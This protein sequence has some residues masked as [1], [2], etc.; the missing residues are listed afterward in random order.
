[1]SRVH[2]RKGLPLIPKQGQRTAGILHRIVQGL[3]DQLIIFNQPVIRIFRKC[4]R[5][6]EKRIQQR[7]LQQSQMRK[8]P[9]QDRNIVT[10]DIMAEQKAGTPA[11][12]VQFQQRIRK[13]EF[14]MKAQLT[15][16]L[17]LDSPDLQN[18]L[19]LRMYLQIERHTAG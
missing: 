4:Q 15:A 1:M 7:K 5:R 12:C 14:P 2:R 13:V 18:P 6:Q 11:K 10:A 9:F 3:L 17:R 19:S 16:V 8:L